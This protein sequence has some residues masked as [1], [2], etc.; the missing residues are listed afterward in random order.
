MPTGAGSRRPPARRGTPCSTRSPSGSAP[1]PVLLGHTLDDQ[2]ETVL[3][4]LTRG[5]G[6]RSIAGMRR[7]FGE[8]RRP[9][10]YDAGRPGSSAPCST[11]DARRP[12]PPAAPRASSSGP[13]RTTP[14]RAS[15]RPG[16]PHRAAAAR[17][18]ARAPASPRRWPAPRSSCAPTWSCSTTWPTTAFEEHY[19]AETGFDVGAIET[20]RAGRP[21]PACCAWRRCA[22][23]ARRRELFAVHVDALRGA[24]LE[25]RAPAAQIQLPGH[26]TAVRDGD[27]L[28]FGRTD[29][30]G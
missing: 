9:A 25:P 1:Q 29:P 21:H 19:D 2:A 30:L 27:H 23:A 7:R 4:G 28:T 24:G 8:R 16:A 17:A 12:R 11:Y 10:A 14:T 5:S 20:L 26:V 18:R 6:G 3:L 22:P 13:T 15:A